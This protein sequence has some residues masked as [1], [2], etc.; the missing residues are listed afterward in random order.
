M[1]LSLRFGE[2]EAVLADINGI[3]STQRT[4]FQARLKNFHRLGF[5]EGIG[6]GRG[7]AVIYTARETVLMAVAVELTQLG[8]TPERVIEVIAADELPVWQ[9]VVMAAGAIIERPE[10]FNAGPGDTGN[11]P[12]QKVWGFSANWVDSD[13]TDPF[14][15]FLYCDPA[16]LAPWD[17]KDADR[18]SS[19]FF[20]GGA[21]IIRDNIS[22]WTTGPTRRLALI[23]VTKL[24][25]D[26]AANLA[27]ENGLE[28]VKEFHAVADGWLTRGDFDLD[29]WLANVAKR[30]MLAVAAGPT[31]MREVIHPKAEW[32][33]LGNLLAD[34]PEESVF[35][36]IITLPEQRPAKGEFVD[37]E[38]PDM[39][40]RLPSQRS[41]M[42]D[43]K[44]TP[45]A[46]IPQE[47]I[48]SRIEELEEQPYR[49]QFTDRTEYIVLYVPSDWFFAQALASERNLLQ[50]A[51]ER[52]IV[53][54]T[55]TILPKLLAE[56]VAAWE[57]Y[58]EEFPDLGT[59]EFTGLP[60]EVWPASA[61][62]EGADFPE[63]TGYGD[64]QE[65]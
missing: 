37:R 10:V 7:K 23:N 54:A 33:T 35:R 42:V 53:I 24:L 64:D 31:D 62:E 28:V 27:V 65:A 6:K 9:S 44:V 43:C 12:D 26:I 1:E 59:E 61:H 20:Y 58:R 47:A 18:A 57:K 38:A 8:L 51:L 4:A 22:R 25:F 36:Y 52:K 3:P 41:L 13:F 11:P 21:G 16:A 45:L 5:P 2:L 32:V 17:E 30:L 48:L 29:D 55:P 15:M 49:T 14:S 34:L 60:G 46:D 40:I 19:T 63:R 50:W 56:V 39:I